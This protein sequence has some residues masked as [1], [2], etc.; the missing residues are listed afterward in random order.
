MHRSPDICGQRPHPDLFEAVRR[1]L[2]TGAKATEYHRCSST[3]A[4]VK[5]QDYYICK[6]TFNF[7]I[8][9]ELSCPYLEDTPDGRAC[10]L[11]GL[12]YNSHFVVGG[13]AFV[14]YDMK[15]TEKILK[16]VSFTTK[17]IPNP[18]ESMLQ[19]KSEAH[20]LIK[21][22]LPKA[23]D[24]EMLVEI[25][26]NTWS[27][28]TQTQCYQMA[29]CRYRFKYHVLVILKCLTTGLFIE[30]TCLIECYSYV[31]KHLPDMKALKA[32]GYKSRWYT[33]AA[34][35]FKSCVNEFYDKSLRT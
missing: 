15:R 26:L 24:L 5:F 33:A 30:Q 4:L 6:T 31:R 21:T 27:N 32:L 7:H 19:Y 12:C 28:L 22:I 34:K 3:C 18:E 25:V 17:R 11:T 23:P 1:T 14:D 9:L 29:K 8:C 2:L 10:T 35:I 20:N 16:P 13:A